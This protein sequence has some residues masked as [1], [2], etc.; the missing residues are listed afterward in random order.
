[1]RC[2]DCNALVTPDLHGCPACRRPLQPAFAATGS[3][4]EKYRRQ[5]AESRDHWSRAGPLEDV[6]ESPSQETSRAGVA[7]DVDAP[8]VLNLLLLHAGYSPLSRVSVLGA[9]P[10]LLQS[11]SL[12]LSCEPVAFH[13][14]TVPLSGGES[15][16]EPPLVTP[17]V[18]FFSTLD[19]AISGE[20]EVTLTAEGQ[21]RARARLPVSIHSSNEWIL[22]PGCEAALAGMVTPNAAAVAAVLTGVDRDFA[23]YQAASSARVGREAEAVHDAVHSLDLRYLGVAPSFEGVGQRVLFPEQVVDARRGSCID[24]AVLVAALLERAGAHPLILLL[25]DDDRGWGHAICGVWTADIRAKSPV[26]RDRQVIDRAVAGSDLLVWDA[27]PDPT[28]GRRPGFAEATQAGRR[29]IRYFE[30]AIDV[31][32]CRDHGFKP[33]PTAASTLRRA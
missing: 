8:G 5:I 19:E 1:M 28:A 4:I 14:K 24:H 15:W 29:L 3:V 22:R 6:A 25:R 30:F 16:V 11:A 12:R 18:E 23:G 9:R 7:L 31:R 32:A 17:D 10:G 21:A 33:L 2:P 13:S 27:T 26:L 20:I